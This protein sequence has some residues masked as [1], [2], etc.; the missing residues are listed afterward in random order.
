M[1]GITLAQSVV[2]NGVTWNLFSVDFDTADGV[3]STYIYAIDHGHAALRLE[4]MK[5]SA[6]IAGQIT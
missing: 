4:E 3:F 6:R 5:E 2:V 1:I